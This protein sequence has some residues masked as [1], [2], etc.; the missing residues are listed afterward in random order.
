ML[1]VFLATAAWLP[2]L[3][4]IGHFVGVRL[5]ARSQGLAVTGMLGL[6]ALAA[7]GTVVHFVAPVGP[8]VAGAAW[9]LGL[10]LFVRDARRLVS[11]T[12]WPT[13]IAMAVAVA[14]FAAASDLPGRHYDMGL[15]WLQAV[16]WTT[17]SAQPLGIATMHARLG[18]NS[19][20][21]TVGAM[22]EG[23]F[24]VGKS[25][26]LAP[27]LVVTLGAWLAAE[28]I[29]EVVG[30]RRTFP[31]WLALSTVLVVAACVQHLGG[32]S[33]DA[34]T[35]V[36]GFAALVAWAR[37]LEDEAALREHAGVAIALTAFA[38]TVKVSAV[39]WLAFSPLLLL[40]RRR[41]ISGELARAAA[42][43]AGLLL[44]WMVDGYLASGCPLFPSTLAC[45]PLPWATPQSIGDEVSGWI[46]SWARMPGVRPEIVLASWDWL[47]GWAEAT[48]RDPIVRLIVWTLAAGAV[49][50][51]ALRRRASPGFWLLLAAA[52]AGAAFWFWGAPT[53]R[54]G[55]AYL[56]ALALLPAAEAAAR[57][58]AG[59][60]RWPAAAVGAAA[61]LA[62]GNVTYAS[63]EW[64]TRVP[65]SAFS[66]V[67]WPEIP[68]PR[69]REVETLAGLRVRMPFQ[70]DQCWSA[71][72][73]CT[74]YFD[75]GLSLEGR[76]F[77]TATVAPS[78]P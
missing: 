9:A 16:R 8:W 10:A 26:F 50:V 47:P 23:P 60:G 40:S 64:I 12:P 55:W 5:G 78:H 72:L 56:F 21:F 49:G 62:A 29:R 17:E 14:L 67:D 52:L 76:V 48:W 30:G 63:A 27:A 15:Y 24:A 35:A 1:A 11:G 73:P 74:P 13:W 20:W 65:A 32:H 70:G 68:N 31:A 36:L 25:A 41:A 75:P 42:P 77:R 6:A 57:L 37:A 58:S 19:S 2:A 39:V 34:A 22:L 61:L 71:P 38:V 51:A 66:P 46:R 3:W 53:P 7:A 33:P 59:G 28:G 43:S 45:L 54:F 69:A 18:F 4:G 44:V